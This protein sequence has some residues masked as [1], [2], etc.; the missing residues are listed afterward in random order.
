MPR[1]KN[2]KMKGNN[3]RNG[4]RKSR[5]QSKNNFGRRQTSRAG[6]SRSENNEA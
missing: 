5:R 4:N 3:R 2:S 6:M 1:Q